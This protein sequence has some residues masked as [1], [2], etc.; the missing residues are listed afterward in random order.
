MPAEY[1]IDHARQLVLS[2][3]HGV[4]T[5]ADYLAHG[6][7]L[8]ADPDFRP[9]YR[10]LWDLTE[11]TKGN[12]NFSELSDMA[13]VNIFAPTARRALLASSDVAFGL[14]RMFQMLRETKGET[15]I[16]VFRDREEALRWLETGVDPD[17]KPRPAGRTIRK[18]PPRG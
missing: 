7:R 17:P 16:R 11:I 3:A 10:Q 4:T 6:H 15:G 2:R 9:D 18:Q 13:K 8:R 14:G 5:T 1:Q 12:T